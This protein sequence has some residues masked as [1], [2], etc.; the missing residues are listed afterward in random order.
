MEEFISPLDQQRLYTGCFYIFDT[1]IR[2]LWPLIFAGW[3]HAAQA[4]QILSMI[5][6]M[7]LVSCGLLILFGAVDKRRPRTV[8]ISVV[9]VVL[10]CWVL[11]TQLGLVGVNIDLE[12]KQTEIR[13]TDAWMSETK[14]SGLSW[15]YGLSAFALFFVL[16]ALNILVWCV[17]PRK[18]SGG[19]LLEQAWHWPANNDLPCCLAR[20]TSYRQIT[21]RENLDSHFQ[22][23]QSCPSPPVKLT[24]YQPNVVSP[25]GVTDIS[26]LD[27][28]T[29]DP[30]SADAF[31]DNDR[32][33]PVP[34]AESK[35][36]LIESLKEK[37]QI[38]ERSSLQIRDPRTAVDLNFS[39]VSSR[40]SSVRSSTNEIPKPLV[41]GKWH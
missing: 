40:M 24:T 41:P 15:S 31:S 3:F 26:S 11:I 22:Q 19:R 2:A 10:I 32:S 17:Y 1:K 34:P 8:M 16:I 29:Y 30:R 39:R 6:Y 21:L 20:G 28:V 23:H 36:D 37:G 25:S 13:G 33:A 35:D 14:F 4:L 27:V 9:L 18:E 7:A 38:E 12:K 5:L